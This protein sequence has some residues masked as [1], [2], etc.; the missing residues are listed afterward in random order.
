MVKHSSADFFGCLK[1]RLKSAA[2]SNLFLRGK[3]SV[4]AAKLLSSLGGQANPALGPAGFNDF[5]T[6]FRGHSG[7]ET[8]GARPLQVTG[9]KSSFHDNLPDFSSTVVQTEKPVKKAA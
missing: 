9:L 3:E 1:T 5:L 2:L 4:S 7:T 6:A 8:M